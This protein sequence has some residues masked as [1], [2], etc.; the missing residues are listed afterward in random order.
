MSVRCAFPKTLGEFAFGVPASPASAPL[1]AQQPNAAQ[2]SMRCSSPARSPSTHRQPASSPGP[3]RTS[4]VAPSDVLL[5]SPV[6]R[7]RNIPT[8]GRWS[9][10]AGSANQPT[11]LASGGG[12]LCVALPSAVGR[13]SSH[14]LPGARAEDPEGFNVLRAQWAAGPS[15]SPRSSSRATVPNLAPR[16]SVAEA[17]RSPSVKH[18]GSTAS[19]AVPEEPEDGIRSI[20]T[21][22]DEGSP[23]EVPT[24]LRRLTPEEAAA[25]IA[26]SVA[27]MA[28]NSANAAAVGDKVCTSPSAA[29]TVDSLNSGAGTSSDSAASDKAVELE[30]LLPACSVREASL[31][32]GAS[33]RRHTVDASSTASAVATPSAGGGGNGSGRV[34][35]ASPSRSF[36]N[37]FCGV[38][39]AGGVQSSP[40]RSFRQTT[41]H[42]STS[43]NSRQLDRRISKASASEDAAALGAASRAGSPKFLPRSPRSGIAFGM[44]LQKRLSVATSVMSCGLT[45]SAADKSD[46]VRL[47]HES[48]P[49]ARSHVEG[50]DRLV[51]PHAFERFASAVEL[52]DSEVGFVA[53]P[54]VSQS[55]LDRLAEV[56]F[57]K[58]DF[59]EIQGLPWGVPVST[60]AEMALEHIRSAAALPLRRR[61]GS[62]SGGAT[63]VDGIT[64]G[65]ST[66]SSSSN[67]AC[68]A[69]AGEEDNS[70]QCVLVVLHGTIRY[71]SSGNGLNFAAK[72][73]LGCCL[74]PAQLLPTHA[75]WYSNTP[76]PSSEPAG[77]ASGEASSAAGPGGSISVKGDGSGASG[78]ASASAN[79]GSNSPGGGS[80]KVSR[81][82]SKRRPQSRTIARRRT[83]E[84]DDMGGL[85]I[86]EA[87]QCLK[88]ATPGTITVQRAPEGGM[89]A[90]RVIAMYLH[91]STDRATAWVDS[92]AALG[93]IIVQRISNEPLYRA[94]ESIEVGKE[95][96]T[97]YAEHIVW[98]GVRLKQDD[99]ESSLAEK[100]QS[101]VVRGFDPKR[102]RKGAAAEGG[103]WLSTAPLSAFGTGNS[104]LS[105]FMLC[106]AKIH[107]NEW[108]D[109]GCARVLQNE[110]VLPLYTLV[111]M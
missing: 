82:A 11:Q 21:L 4:T 69:A 68:A 73:R 60:T 97:R 93:S 32:R 49:K 83:K 6:V 61:S 108:V 25:R 58:E 106:V 77:G 80:R 92:R 33:R 41:G 43:G 17:Q 44:S 86:Q 54:N 35:S 111:H 5:A 47:F 57:R 30:A 22:A 19:A 78:N 85:L 29:T 102:C 46:V 81:S 79:A 1:S 98:H 40:S 53:V 94:Y 37:S 71:R 13:T 7:H 38:E 36:R 16:P 52:E 26:E 109:G 63:A 91:M 84:Y 62:V 95:G 28:A 105:A 103:I 101:I 75:V 107:F 45:P 14:T 27:R 74:D 39:S 55:L 12:S 66:S 90:E 99:A 20:H 10:A 65:R 34:S 72:G 76:A 23:A 89:E 70:R 104:Y 2:R 100:L 9:F 18:P 96:P 31:P 67:N 50:V 24:G 64:F 88:E 51:T 3:R 87:T 15:A 56:G 42:M 48:I 8:M 59:R 110:R